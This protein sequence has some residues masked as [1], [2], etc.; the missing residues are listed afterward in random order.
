[1]KR[2]VYVGLIVVIFLAMIL[3]LY[4]LYAN[5]AALWSAGK[6]H[7]T[8]RLAGQLV[9]KLPDGYD[10]TEGRAVIKEYLVA[11]IEQRLHGERVEEVGELFDAMLR[12]KRLTQDEADRLMEAM[13]QVVSGTTGETRGHE[14]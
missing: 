12:G 3:A 13:R 8:D 6:D 9:E 2:K 11:T 10:K 14:N 7:M 4:L 5:R 1:M